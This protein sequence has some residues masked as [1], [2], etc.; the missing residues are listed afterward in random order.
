MTASAASAAGDL[1]ALVGG[2]G[3]CISFVE[4]LEGIR[5]SIQGI[6]ATAAAAA[7][8]S[9]AAASRPRRRRRRRGFI[10]HDGRKANRLFIRLVDSTKEIVFSLMV[11]AEKGCQAIIS[12]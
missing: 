1:D 5:K 2:Q 9:D 10:P 6:V 8:G 11:H 3:L 4:D 12:R 7:V